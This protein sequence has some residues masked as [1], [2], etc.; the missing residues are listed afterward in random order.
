MRGIHPQHVK[1]AIAYPASVVMSPTLTAS[2]R[3]CPVFQKMWLPWL[4]FHHRQT[5]CPRNRSRNL[6]TNVT[7]RRNQQNS[8]FTLTYHPQNLAVRNVIFKN[9][10]ILCN[11]PE[12]KHVFPLPPL[13][14]FKCGKNRGNFLVRSAFKSDNQP[15]T[16]KCTLTR[17]KV[18]LLFLT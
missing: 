1:N 16:F 8:M 10:K 5:P 17:F 2:A 12:T 7:E 13:I 3:K 14:S 4:C 6:T 9:F 15:G 18:V 11:D